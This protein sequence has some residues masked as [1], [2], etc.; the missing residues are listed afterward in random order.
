MAEQKLIRFKA[1]GTYHG[2]SVRNNNSVDLSFKFGYDELVNS[3][4]LIQLLNENISISAKAGD[5][6]P[7]SLGVFM[8]KDIKVDHDGQVVAKFNSQTDYVELDNFKYLVGELVKLMFQAKIEIEAEEP[9]E[10]E[11]WTK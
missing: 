11:K 7:F 3:I 5:H 8:I 1:I 2:H 10:R 9:E 6:K 4:K